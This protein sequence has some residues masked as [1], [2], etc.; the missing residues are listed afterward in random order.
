MSYPSAW[1]EMDSESRRL[2]FGVTP[3]ALLSELEAEGDFKTSVLKELRGTG[4]TDFSLTLILRRYVE[5]L[6]SV[7]GKLREAT[8]AGV[9]EE[10]RIV[11]AALVRARRELGENLVGLVV[12]AGPGA[13]HAEEHHFVNERSWK[14]REVLVKKNSVLQNLARRYVAAEHPSG[15]A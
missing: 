6:A 11:E 4:K 13:E 3:S 12:I 1:E 14:R 10:H 8:R 15:V 2:R 7:H 9:E 5:S